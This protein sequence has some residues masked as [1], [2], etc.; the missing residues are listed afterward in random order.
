[1]MNYALVTGGVGGIGSAVVGRFVKDGFTVI[2][3]DIDEPHG[4][5]SYWSDSRTVLYRKVDISNS[6]D[7]AELVAR[8]YSD[9]IRL[10]HCV[11]LAGGALPQEFWPLDSVENSVIEQSIRLNLQSH[12][13]L[14]RNVLPLFK[15]SIEQN[16]SITFISSINAVMDFGLPIYSAAKAGLL[17]L[18]RTL[19]SEWGKYNVRVNCVLP[20]TVMTDRTSEEPKNFAEYL[21]GSVLN[22]FATAD[23]IAEIIFCV[24]ETLTCI[25]GQSLVADCGQTIKGHYL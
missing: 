22:R 3:A 16:R 5:E 19:A 14:A 12:I 8:L 23:E 4:Q 21:K 18:T 15:E 6:E 10:K 24:A 25:T 17:G 7:V 13:S 9:E 20:G 2:V 1:M 11:S